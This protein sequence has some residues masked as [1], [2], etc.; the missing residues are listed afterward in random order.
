MNSYCLELA[1]GQRWHIIGVSETSQWVNKLASIMQLRICKSNNHSKLLIIRKAQSF[2]R[3]AK[4][5][6]RKYLNIQ[7]PLPMK[8]CSLHE[9]GSLRFR[10]CTE[11]PDIICEIGEEENWEKEILKMWHVF[12]PISQKTQ[13]NGGLP[14]HG[15]LVEK[16]GKGIILAA[17]G[18]TGKSTCC[19]RIP[20]PWSPLC[21]NETLIVKGKNG[22][23]LAHPF[24]TWSEYLCK[25]SNKTW[26]V[27]DYVPLQAIFFLEQ[28]ESDEALPLGKGEATTK[29]IQLADQVFWLRFFD[30]NKKEKRSLN[31]KLFKN[32]SEI[33]TAVPSFI[34]RVTL[35]GSFWEEMDKVLL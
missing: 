31:L 2:D 12:I 33:A 34:L 7:N 29:I 5:L 6:F 22:K 26:D 35:K 1:D 17:S 27:K 4:P 14:L 11:K 10:Y 13:D 8:K 18:G 24:P 9:L 20:S 28:S 23:Y 3:N 19:L 15:A 32:A 21:D 30:V 16:Q 25:G